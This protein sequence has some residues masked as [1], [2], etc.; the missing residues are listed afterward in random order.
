MK[1]T[2]YFSEFLKVAPLSLA[3]W[4]GI[5]AYQ[6]SKIDINYK[7]PILDIGCGIGEFAGV[8]FESKVEVGVDIDKKDILKAQKV[9]KYKKLVLTDARKL[10]FKDASFNTVISNSV[11]EHIPAVARVFKESFRVLK[12][13]G[14]LIYTVPI[15]S[16]YNNLFY[17]RLL[18]Y[19]GLKKTS[20][21]YYRLLNKVF[22]HIN[23]TPC[24]NWKNMTKNA[25]F[26]IITTHE[27]ISPQATLIFDLTI[28]LALPSQI[29]RWLFGNRFILNFPGRIWLCEKLFGSLISEEVKKGS[30]LLV[31]ARKS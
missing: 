18:Q 19:L 7:N 31:I 25:G 28:L 3:I 6:M 5:E 22:K 13:G 14:Y 27:M 29:S 15:G 23:I 12:P 10:P 1:D 21:L 8:F 16:L 17:T 2:Q 11:L 4:R 24:D 26:K 20:L 30:N 9:N